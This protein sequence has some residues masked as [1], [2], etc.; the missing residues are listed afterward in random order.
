MPKP[1]KD[2]PV[3]PKIAA[4]TPSVVSMMIQLAIFGMMCRVILMIGIDPHELGGLDILGLDKLL[5]HGAQD[6][7]GQH[8]GE[9]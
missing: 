4:L 9:Q 6:A 7:S 5:S 1:M 8:P 2:S 3:S